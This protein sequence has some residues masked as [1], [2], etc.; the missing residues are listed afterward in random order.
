VT[1]KTQEVVLDILF[2]GREVTSLVAGSFISKVP[3][4]ED[5]WRGII[6]FGLNVASYKFALAKSLLELKPEAGQLIK[7]SELAPIYSR[8]IA[9][10]IKTADKQGTSGSS[11]FLDACRKFN[12]G[13]LSPTMLTEQTIRYGFNNVIDAF[14][15]VRQAEIPKK[16]YF[17]ERKNND[18]IRITDEF[19]KLIGQEQS[20]NL[21]LE[22]EARWRLV[23][24]AWELGVSRNIVSINYDSKTESLF[25]IDGVRR[26]SITG[27]RDALIGYQKGKCFYCFTDVHIN[28]GETLPEVDHFFPHILK[29]QGFGAIIDGVWNLV[30]SCQGCNR[31]IG[32]KFDRVPSLRLLE[33]LHTRNEFLISSHHPLRETLIQQTGATGEQRRV[34]LNDFHG[35]AWASLIHLWE[36][37]EKDGPQ[38]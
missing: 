7:I 18:G 26:R 3:K 37:V 24:T 38:F 10:H 32:G 25:S 34:F 22:V 19:S 1:S 17:D 12:S 4:L 27:C 30:L 36:S 6:L 23:E 8:H 11:K 16:F 14:H 15:V 2:P 20:D 31:G 9:E 35:K 13:E 21:P 29:Q 28:R 33:R 5:Y